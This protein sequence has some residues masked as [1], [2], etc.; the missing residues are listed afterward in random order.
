MNEI[1]GIKQRFDLLIFR[2]IIKK[3]QKLGTKIDA[4]EKDCSDPTEQDVVTVPLTFKASAEPTQWSNEDLL[5]LI[6]H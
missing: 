2:L 6:R 5:M 3:L 4:E 1:T